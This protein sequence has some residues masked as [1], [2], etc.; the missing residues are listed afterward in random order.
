M[1]VSVMPCWTIGVDWTTSSIFYQNWPEGLYW[2]IVKR[3]S[4]EL[5][6]LKSLWSLEV[7]GQFPPAQEQMSK[8]R[9]KLLK[10]LPK[11]MSRQGSIFLL[12]FQSDFSFQSC[13]SILVLW[14]DS[15]WQFFRMFEEAADAK[16]GNIWQSTS[17]LKCNFTSRQV[18]YCWGELFLQ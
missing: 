7:L 10:N 13:F 16:T 15:I 2:K 5:V 17:S 12:K 3:F 11:T 18:L 1:T 6:K 4:T 14:D 8:P 9:L